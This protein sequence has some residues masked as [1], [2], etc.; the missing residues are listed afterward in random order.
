MNKINMYVCINNF[1]PTW[2][3]GKTSPQAK[4]TFFFSFL[5]GVIIY[6]K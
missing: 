5:Y 4:N 3:T 1:S 6:K 2:G